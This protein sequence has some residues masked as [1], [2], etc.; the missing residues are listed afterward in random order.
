MG[1]G[2]KLKITKQLIE[3]QKASL[4]LEKHC[5]KVLVRLE[6]SESNQKLTN[7]LENEY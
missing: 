1:V 4:V 5:I 3:D 6:R 2:L 7:N